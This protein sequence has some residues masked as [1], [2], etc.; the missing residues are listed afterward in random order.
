MINLAKAKFPE[1]T[2]GYSLDSIAR[3]ELWD[4]SLNYGHGTGHGIGHFLSVH[5]G[6]MSI[7]SEFNAEPIRAGQILTDEPGLYRE[8]Q[9]GIRIENVLVCKNHA[10]SAFGQFLSF[11]KLTLCPIDKKLINRKLLNL[12]EVNW[13]NAYHKRVFSALKPYLK[14]E[15]SN[16]LK[17]QCSSL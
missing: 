8:G 14:P 13:L 12:E 4:N 2:K 1:N 9:Y 15:I 5:E 16:W 3:K 10:N 11:D 17:I 7:R 6:P